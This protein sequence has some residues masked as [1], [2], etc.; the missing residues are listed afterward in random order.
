MFLY[1]HA[2]SMKPSDRVPPSTDECD[3]ST[4]LSMVRFPSWHVPALYANVLKRHSRTRSRA[5]L[6]AYYLSLT[7][8]DFR[9]IFGCCKIAADPTVFS[10]RM[11]CRLYKSRMK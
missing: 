6:Y 9:F 1:G 7:S 8:R 10:A 2:S 11:E 4:R 3:A 5:L